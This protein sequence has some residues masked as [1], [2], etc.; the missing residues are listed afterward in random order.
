[1][2]TVKKF[3]IRT[4]SVETKDGKNPFGVFQNLTNQDTELLESFDTLEEAIASFENY[5]ATVRKDHY[6]VTRYLHDCYVIEENEYD[7]DGEWVA[8]GDWWEVLSKEWEEEEDEE[9]E[10]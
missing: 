1:M 4:F 9:E 2:K 5:G 10:E 3:E 6:I 8:G 7:E